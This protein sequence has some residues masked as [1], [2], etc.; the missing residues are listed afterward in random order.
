MCSGK[1][2]KVY[3][4]CQL[5]RNDAFRPFELHSSF[6]Q[7]FIQHYIVKDVIPSCC[8]HFYIKIKNLSIKNIKK[9]W[10]FF[11]FFPLGKIII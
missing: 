10:Y 5:H 3:Q 9:K 11:L 8:F 1:T 4:D 7:D 2:K 6:L